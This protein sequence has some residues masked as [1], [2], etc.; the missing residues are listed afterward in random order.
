MIEAIKRVTKKEVDDEEKPKVQEE[1]VLAADD[2][3]KRGP[4]LVERPDNVNLFKAEDNAEAAEKRSDAIA[5][6]TDQEVVEEAAKV[7]AIGE[8]A[9]EAEDDFLEEFEEPVEKDQPAAPVDPAPKEPEKQ[10]DAAA[11]E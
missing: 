1:E 2:D 7:D 6:Q 5:E 4:G 3:A 11:Y 10:E 9:K 8:E